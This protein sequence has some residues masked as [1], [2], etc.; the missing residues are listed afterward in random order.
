MNGEES[1][2]KLQ[3]RRANGFGTPPK[4]FG[5]RVGE[6][7]VLSGCPARERGELHFARFHVYSYDLRS[8]RTHCP[9]CIQNVS[10]LS[11]STTHCASWLIVPTSA[12]SIKLRL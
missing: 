7:R 9:F 4:G 6:F 10:T 12:P 1:P 3:R 5:R 2:P 8:I 11:E